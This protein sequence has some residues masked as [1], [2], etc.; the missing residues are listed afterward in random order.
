[1]RLGMALGDFL[2][3]FVEVFASIRKGPSWPFSL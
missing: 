3:H 2:L 1:L